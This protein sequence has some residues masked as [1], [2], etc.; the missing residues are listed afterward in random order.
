LLSVFF[1]QPFLAST[2][3]APV[4]ARHSIV[5]AA[6]RT[7]GAHIWP[8]S[9]AESIANCAIP[10]LND[11]ASTVTVPVSPTMHRPVASH[12]DGVV[13]HTR[14]VAGDTAPLVR[15]APAFARESPPLARHVA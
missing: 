2:P 15:H 3:H 1:A 12:D 9:W 11:D 5:D 7:F 10:P 6:Y 13:H 4:T 8:E 14:D